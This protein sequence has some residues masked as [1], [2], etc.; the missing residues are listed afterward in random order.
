MKKATRLAILAAITGSILG[1]GTGPAQASPGHEAGATAGLA[2]ACGVRE[3]ELREFIRQSMAALEARARS[4]EELER[5]MGGFADAFAR[6]AF[7]RI[8]GDACA[9]LPQEFQRVYRSMGGK[10]TLVVTG[11]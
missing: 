6:A 4:A 1:A 11:S 2:V 8:P 9:A 5:S 10:R 3:P 7:P